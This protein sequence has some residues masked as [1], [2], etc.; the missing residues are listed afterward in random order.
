LH[1]LSKYH[2]S[3]ST[4]PFC[5]SYFSVRIS[6]FLPRPTSDS[7]PPPDLCLLSIWESS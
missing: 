5:F 4:S 1:L 6:H 3:H 2:L 7:N